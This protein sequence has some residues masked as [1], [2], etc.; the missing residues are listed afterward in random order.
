MTVPQAISEDDPLLSKISPARRGD[1]IETYY[2]LGFSFAKMIVE[3]GKTHKWAIDLIREIPGYEP[4]MIK[5]WV[6]L[7]S[8]DN[9]KRSK[10]GR[11][12]SS[13]KPK[14]VYLLLSGYIEEHN[15]KKHG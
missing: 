9:K 1:L 8:R 4:W 14:D 5:H 10:P 3:G 6:S 2:E 12:K 7:F 15:F 13:N 11:K